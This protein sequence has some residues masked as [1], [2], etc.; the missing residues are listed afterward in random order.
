M[1][2]DN[3]ESEVTET[4]QLL[5]DVTGQPAK[6]KMTP[7]RFDG[8]IKN[9]LPFYA[10]LDLG[11]E[12]HIKL[13]EVLKQD[14]MGSNWY[15][16]DCGYKLT[17]GMAEEI[18]S[19][20]YSSSKGF[21]K[22][23]MKEDSKVI[24]RGRSKFLKSSF[25]GMNVEHPAFMDYES[26]TSESLKGDNSYFDSIYLSLMCGLKEKGVELPPIL[27]KNGPIRE[28]MHNGAMDTLDS[29]LSGK[30]E[31]IK[32][33]YSPGMFK[34]A[35]FEAKQITKQGLIRQ[36]YHDS[37]IPLLEKMVDWDT[38]TV[39][40]IG[41]KTYN[42]LVVEDFGQF[43]GMGTIGRLSEKIA[44]DLEDFGKYGGTNIFSTVNLAQCMEIC[45]TGQVDAILMDGGY[46]GLGGA[47]KIMQ[48]EGGG[49]EVLQNSESVDFPSMDG[50]GEKK[51]WKERIFR[52][53]EENGHKTP[54]CL[55][56]PK[57]IMQTD[58]GRFVAEM[59]H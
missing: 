53:V 40:G 35:Q 16:E 56:V 39:P 6:L 7:E 57:D 45:G 17:D 18:S 51:N 1:Q 36:Q 42:V 14:G 30:L 3:L 9:E 54:S 58:A 32:D 26:Y 50:F 25:G 21:N 44:G 2:N 22:W 49:L 47:Q 20:H 15:A 11:D 27:S 24:D 13:W 43:G 4:I 12:Y 46:F 41:D 5:S 29:L 19:K 38:K 10:S 23:E 55:I 33:I 52:V 31:G 34:H 37:R 59:L 28:A 8:E 48:Q